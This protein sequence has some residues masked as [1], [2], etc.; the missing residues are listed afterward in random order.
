M[1][2]D[3][4]EECNWAPFDTKIGA[5]AE[6]TRKKDRFEYHNIDI[7]L[8]I[9]CLDP[10]KVNDEA[11]PRVLGFFIPVRYLE[12]DEFDLF[13]Q[14]FIAVLNRLAPH[15]EAIA[16][17]GLT[18]HFVTK[19]EFKLPNAK[20]RKRLRQEVSLRLGSSVPVRHDFVREEHRFDEIV[21]ATLADLTDNQLLLP[22]LTRG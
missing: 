16:K 13:L 17:Q 4:P 9:V 22:L 6:K 10:A 12:G 11:L 20:N 7:D 5:L 3:G 19:D 14:R 8:S 18:F 15:S 21:H 2:F 1:V